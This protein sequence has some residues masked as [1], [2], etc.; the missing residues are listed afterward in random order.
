VRDATPMWMV[1]GPPDVNRIKEPKKEAPVPISVTQLNGLNG[2]KVEVA[3]SSVVI[4]GDFNNDGMDDLVIGSATADPAGRTGAGATYVVFGRTSYSPIISEPGVG[5]ATGFVIRGVASGDSSGF[6]VDYVDLNGDGIADIVIGAPFVDFGGRTDAGSVYVVYGTATPPAS[7]FELSSLNGTNGFVLTGDIANDGARAGYSVSAG[8][9]FN[10]DGREDLLVGSPFPGSMFGPEHAYAYVVYGAAGFAAAVALSSIT[11]AAGITYQGSFQDQLGRDV[12][13]V[14]DVN[15]DGRPDI[16]ITRFFEASIGI[17][18]QPTTGG[19]FFGPP[20]AAVDANHF[21]QISEEGPTNDVSGA[22]DINGDGID[23]FI[24]ALHEDEAFAYGRTASD[25]VRINA[26]AVIVYGRT[27]G[28]EGTTAGVNS[29]KGF[30]LLSPD[31]SWSVSS[32]GDFNGD[33]IADVIVSAGTSAYVVFGSNL[34]RTDIDLRN[35]TSSEGLV[36]TDVGTSAKVAGAGDVNDDGFDDVAITSSLGTYVVF[37]ASLPPGAGTGTNG[38]DTL[39]GTA[40]TDFLDGRG[41]NDNLIALGGDDYLIGGTGADRMEGGSGSDTYY[42]DNAGDVIVE[43]ALV[44]NDRVATTISYTL[45]ADADIELFEAITQSATDAMNLTGNGFGQTIV[46][47][48]GVNILRG[49]GADDVLIGLGGDDYLVGGVGV[50]VMDGGLG[51]DTYYVD[52]AGDAVHELSSQGLDRVAASVSWVLPTGAEIELL[53]AV[54]LSATDAINLTGNAFVNTV[55]GNNG[56]NVLDG[57]GGNDF[58]WGYGGND[59]LVGGSSFDE[60]HGGA[61]DDLYYVDDNSDRP[62]EAA[63]EGSDRVATSVSFNMAYGNDEIEVIEAITLAATTPIDI[64]G[65]GANNTIIGNN[66]ANTLDG[67]GGSDV[68]VGAGGADVFKFEFARGPGDIDRIA[69]FLSGTDKIALNDEF[70]PGLSPGALPAGAFATGSQA[71]DADDRIVYNGATGALYFDADG[72]GAG[73]MVQFAILQ[74]APAI[75]AAD[76]TVI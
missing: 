2:F 31:L 36:I 54:T 69:D 11:G 30:V 6:A 28:W 46:G 62:I 42:V 53:E 41:G 37:G 24:V 57:G 58:L 65:S 67:V 75:T 44:G 16:L 64:N 40:G 19:L 63:G 51:G 8:G 15:G 17:P 50:D 23:D 10:Q 20:G 21:W 39:T 68:L 71:G 9:D 72:S 74:G 14:G 38:D 47:N 4:R 48:A 43:P 35:L 27:G 29:N 22:G 73:A 60:M 18:D 12:A 55:R 5:G 76:F 33:G 61:G 3:G 45:S 70:F 66:G 56:G 32:A 52:N 49:E 34:A 7:S 59:V 1:A 13:D 26:A 25:G